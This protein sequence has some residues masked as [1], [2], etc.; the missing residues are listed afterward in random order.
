M[1]SDWL[2]ILKVISNI[3]F[4]K[5]SCSYLVSFTRLTAAPTKILILQG[6]LKDKSY[7]N[8]STIAVNWYG[9]NFSKEKYLSA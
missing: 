1:E 4:L 2:F 8:L 9:E 6:E 3:F 7:Q 5:I